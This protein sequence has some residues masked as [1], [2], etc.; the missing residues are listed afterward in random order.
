LLKNTDPTDEQ[1]RAYVDSIISSADKASQLSRKMLMYAG[2]QPAAIECYNLF[3][4]IDGMMPLLSSGFSRQHEVILKPAQEEVLARVDFTQ[5]EQ[6]VLNLVT[7][8]HR[9]IDPRQGRIQISVGKEAIMDVNDP[10]LFGK[11]ESRGVFSYIEV[12]DNGAG[13]SEE[14]I[15]RIF[16]PFYSDNLQGRGLGLALVYGLVNQHSGFIR[17]RSSVGKGTS[18]RVYFPAT[19]GPASEQVSDTPSRVPVL[20]KTGNVVVIDDEPQVL[21]VA[22]RVAQSHGWTAHIFD[23]GPAG[24]SFLRETKVEIDGVFVDIRMPVMDGRQ[25]VERLAND[26]PDLPVAMM[27]GYSRENLHDFIK[28]GNVLALLEKP[29]T[30]AAFLDTL[31]RVAETA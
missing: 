20:P 29:F 7:N 14:K 27:S 16:E 2:K 8:A 11:R 28:F 4:L 12:A 5:A 26:F 23:N 3:H 13:I 25:V 10:T 9:A 1:R 31:G 21:E 18:F 22:E 30:S 19:L 6:I 24:I 15:E 17:V